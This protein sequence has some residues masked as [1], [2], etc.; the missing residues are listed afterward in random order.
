MTFVNSG[1]SPSL[2]TS[3]YYRQQ[4][5]L[6]LGEV[7]DC[8]EITQIQKLFDF[9]MVMMIIMIIVVMRKMI[10]EKELILSS[11]SFDPVKSEKL[12]SGNVFLLLRDMLKNK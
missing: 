11:R 3:S 2:W 4:L 5:G 1:R 9:M 6:F 7:S 8:I 12:L 10:Q